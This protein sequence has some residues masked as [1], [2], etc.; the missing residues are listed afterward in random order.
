MEVSSAV[1][2]HF[3]IEIVRNALMRSRSGPLRTLDDE[4]AFYRIE[5]LGFQVG[6][7]H[8]ERLLSPIAAA[9]SSVQGR[10]SDPLEAIKYLCKEYWGDVFGKQVDNLKTNHRGVYVLYDNQFSWIGRFSSSPAD[11]SD[12]ARMAVLV[13][14]PILAL[15]N[16]F[17][18]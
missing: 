11:C 5:Q 2:N 16:K 17:S 3:Y 12:T 6:R 1:W 8:I 9:S 10:F 7:R 4:G 15:I 18:I 13:H 14:C